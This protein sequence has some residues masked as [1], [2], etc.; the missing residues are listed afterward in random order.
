MKE[1]K[2]I[3]GADLHLDS[4]MIG[5]SHLPKNIFHR[6]QESTFQALKALVDHAIR[7]QVD[8]VV[9]AGDL[10]DNEDRSI[11]AQ[12]RL[13]KEFERLEKEGIEV[14]LVFGN[15]DHMGG[16]WV[17]VAMPKNVQIFGGEVEAKKFVSTKGATVFLYGFSYL[18]RHTFNK[19]IDGYMKAN[20]GDFHVAMLHGNLEGNVEHG[21]YAPFQLKDL[22]EKEFDYW[23]LGHIHKRAVLH[24]D[25][26]VVYP[27]NTQGRNKKEKGP[28]GCYLVTLNENGQHL[29]FME[30][31]DCIWSD[32]IIDGA[33]FQ[34]F[35]HLYEACK[36]KVL[37]IRVEGKGVLTEITVENVSPDFA[38][39]S[40]A[41]DLLD[42]L[43]EEEKEEVSFVWPVQINI[44]NSFQWDREN[45]AKESNFFHELFDIIDENKELE[46]SLTP[47]YK[48]HLGRKFLTSLTEEELEE[49]KKDAE[50]YLIEQL[51]MNES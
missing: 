25:P 46:D 15:H 28:K 4:P 38:N 29:D 36:E 32:I 21:N 10:F 35:D 44:N 43:Q 23:A 39:P 9:L 51:L 19:R 34:S 11:R 37:D 49:L 14:F 13:R 40:L 47:L 45:L 24:E 30:T 5:L 1:I 27:G 12:T 26:L 3:H 16:S 7:N 22:L 41:A 50:R 8:F 33:S 20:D 31:S 6:L 18:K 48:H 17:H 42:V 2:F